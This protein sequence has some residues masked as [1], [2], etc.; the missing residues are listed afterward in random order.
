MELNIDI[1]AIHLNFKHEPAAFD[2]QKYEIGWWLTNPWKL[3]K[4]LYRR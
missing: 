4:E 3:T 1:R 2:I